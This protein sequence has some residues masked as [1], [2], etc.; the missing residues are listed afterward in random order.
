M[1]D[2]IWSVYSYIWRQDEEVTEKAI[3]IIDNFLNEQSSKS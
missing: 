3:E 2:C 1:G